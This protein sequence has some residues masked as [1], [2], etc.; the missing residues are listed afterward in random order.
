MNNISDRDDEML[1]QIASD[2][3]RS[4]HRDRMETDTVHFAISSPAEEDF[5][6]ALTKRVR[7]IITPSVSRLF[8]KYLNETD[9]LDRYLEDPD[10]E[11]LNSY[12]EAF[13]AE[14][15][16]SEC[17]EL[18]KRLPALIGMI[19]NTCDQYYAVIS[20]MLKRMDSCYDEICGILLK[21]RPFQTLYGFS[22]CGDIHNHGRAT[23]IL[24]LDTG[25]VVY[26]P[27]DVRIDLKYYELTE[28][29]FQD[30][31]K[32]PKV[33][34]RDGYGF[35]EFIENHP[36]ETEE[37]ARQYFYSLGGLVSVA[38]MLG[39]TD[40][41]HSNV[42]ACGV[43]PVVID[44]EL[45]ITPGTVYRKNSLADD[46]S[47]S[48][49]YS[50]LMPC[51][52]GDTELSVLFAADE[53]NRS[54]P[55]V[56]GMRRCVL[57]YPEE[58]VQGFQ[59]TYFRCM[60]CREEIKA[61]IS[62]M[63][64]I[65][66]R[67]IY[68]STRDYCDVIDRILEPG[69]I[70]D[71]NLR[72]ELVQKFSVA[73]K[74]S[75]SVQAGDIT[76][77]ETDAVLRGEIPY[78]CARTDSCDL[79]ADGRV[80]FRNFFQQSCLDHVLSRID[81]LSEIDRAFETALLE[82]AMTRVIRKISPGPETKQSITEKKE[83]SDKVLLDHAEQIFRLISSDAVKTPS[84]HFC[85]FGPDYF[86]ETGMKLLD[87]GLY[88][89]ITGLAVFFAA[90]HSFSTDAEIQKE[91]KRYLD[92]IVQRLIT[93]AEELSEYNVIYPNVENTSLMT[94]FAGK[95]LG[96]R[97]IW[98]YTKEENCQKLYRK[99]TEL[100][101]RV[102]LQYERTDIYSGLS[103]LLKLLVS[104]DDLF[105]EPGIPEYCELLADH[106]KASARIPY[107]GKKIWKTLSPAWAISGAGHGQSGVASALYL[108]GKRLNRRDLLEAA[109]AGFVF[110][111]EIYSE[112]IGAW[113]DRRR[114]EHTDKYLTGY[115]S[116]APGIGL[117]ALRLPYENAEKTL[118]KAIFSSLK[119]PL[120]YKDF[121]CCGNSAV[122]EF[123]LEA[124]RITGKRELLEEARTR[125][126]LVIERADQN[127]HYNCVNRNVSDVFSPSL[128]YGVSGI[129]YEM[130]RL[131]SPENMESVLL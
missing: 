91:T 72:E 114:Q 109:E 85:W 55:V 100:V 79:Y 47:H 93:S 110:E 11:E 3:I 95:I 20:E 73:M 50:T 31:L 33:I 43:Y 119:E 90:L 112:T 58:F 8:L 12:R 51:R 101:Q 118:E 22:D 107:R 24:A 39:S 54:A 96:C 10:A 21:D 4:L 16:A 84:D 76:N 61:F 82:K 64:G 83:L 66:V 14:L 44:C 56:D 121:L 70:K 62:S 2:I 57:D 124:G 29:F 67:H 103:G 77:A 19:R 106:I 130:L 123:L 65:E 78:F 86:L 13:R 37:E 34:S 81:H 102:D 88:T 116:G 69:W 128:L 122:I 1:E 80:V 104:Y 125:M 48:L 45:L 92:V 131:I 7:R 18:P 17:S 94:G 87:S 52:R 108:A 98:S 9:M 38:Q 99:L 15:T 63:S 27:H 6:S 127:G 115:C 46:L 41:H 36:A 25:N 60:S 53:G 111:E 75:G 113:P 126:A 74:R 97:I 40:L 49:L 5:R 35:V 42:L 105:C 28:R 30:I 32:A 129:G 117:N 71:S 68:R 26:K 23:A 59:E 89:G 120:Q